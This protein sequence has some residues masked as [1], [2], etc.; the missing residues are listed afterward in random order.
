MAKPLPRAGCGVR[1]QQMAQCGSVVGGMLA[2]YEEVYIKDMPW[3][4]GILAFDDEE[5]V[6]SSTPTRTMHSTSAP[7]VTSSR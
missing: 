2:V 4:H 6:Y 1:A 7:V 3:R 5:G